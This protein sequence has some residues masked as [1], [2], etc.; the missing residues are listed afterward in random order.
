MSLFDKKPGKSS[1]ETLKA[2][3]LP[4]ASEAAPA[5]PRAGVGISLEAL[6]IRQ[7]METELAPLKAKHEDW[8]KGVGQSPTVEEYRRI[9]ELARSLVDLRRGRVPLVSETEHG[10][11]LEH[12]KELAKDLESKLN[13]RFHEFGRTETISI[14]PPELPLGLTQEHL[15]T[16]RE[17]LS[18]GKGFEERVLPT[19]SDLRDLDETYE[20]VMYPEIQNEA[21]KAKGLVSHR[22]DWWNTKSDLK[23]VTGT[24]GEVYL[25]SMRQELDALGGSLIQLDTATKPS[26]TD[27]KQ[28]YGTKEGADPAADTLLPLFRE[29]FGPDANRF[30]HSWDDLEAKL[31]PLAKR[32][33]AETLKAKGLS[34][35]KFEVILVPA[36][37]DN[38]EMTFNH[39]ES[40]TTNTYEWTSTTIMD[41]S[42][43]DTGRRLVVGFSDDGGAGYVVGDARGYSSGRLGARLAVVWK[44]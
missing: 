10:S 31:L 2:T 33:I 39:P 3:K 5:A 34:K 15:D 6:D 1:P 43:N 8:K 29:A 25:R 32:K 27:G 38:L 35:V 40:S 26:Y 23:N 14:K 7:R 37:L 21:D 17:A 18:G 30:S 22:P 24:W 20:S 9:T 13:D 28:Q 11:L 4:V 44:K 36:T 42:G 41:D 19:L 12:S 16:V